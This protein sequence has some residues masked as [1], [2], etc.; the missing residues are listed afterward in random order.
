[1]KNVCMVNGSPSGNSATSLAF[2]KDLDDFL[3][4]TLFRKEYV[5]LNMK[6]GE[7]NPVAS[8]DAMAGSDALI[9]SFPLYAYTLPAPFTRLLE[10]YCKR[11]E[12]RPAEEKAA[13]VY[14]IVN[15]GYPVPD[16]NAEALRVMKNFCMRAGLFWRFGTAIGGGLVVA[17]TRNVPIVNRKL[18]KVYGLIRE[19][20]QGCGL[21]PLSDV[22]IKPVIPK[23]MMIYMKDSRWAKRYMGRRP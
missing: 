14:A 3:D 16:V 13:R 6:A 18:L 19:D 9:F 10:D 5:S 22:S 1:M 4:G 21:K 20:I 15:S 8:M 17:M 11:K 2:L 7:T 12:S 23:G